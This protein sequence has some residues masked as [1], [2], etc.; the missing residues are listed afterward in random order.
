MKSAARGFTIVELLIVVLVIGILAA[1]TFVA[2]NGI[3]SRADTDA[4]I[5]ETHAWENL[6]YAYVVNEG[7]MPLPSGVSIENGTGETTY[8]LGTGFQD[9]DYR[10]GGYDTGS[11]RNQYTSDVK[12]RGHVEPNLNTEL[13]KYGI[14]PKGPRSCPAGECSIGP[15][16]NFYS[17]TS[18]TLANYFAATACPSGYTEFDRYP[19]APNTRIV[20]CQKIIN[21]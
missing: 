20:G 19:A 9:T 8:C 6:L 17:T 14:L 4:R 18:A 12:T 21:A 5:S 13:A 11:C 16:V 15:Y 2:F 1:I 3:T 10:V 7:K